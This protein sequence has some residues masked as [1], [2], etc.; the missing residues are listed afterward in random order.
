MK[1]S[2]DD[3]LVGYID[4]FCDDRTEFPEQSNRSPAYRHGWLNGR[5]DRVGKPRDTAENL[6]RQAERILHEVN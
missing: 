3:M 4:G 6:G 5:D 1:S 2:D